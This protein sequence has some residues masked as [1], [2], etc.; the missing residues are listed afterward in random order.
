ML[1]RFFILN[2]CNFWILNQCLMVF[3][4]SSSKLDSD[5]IQLS[6]DAE[7]IINMFNTIRQQD[8]WKETLYGCRFD[9]DTFHFRN[10]QHFMLEINNDNHLKQLRLLLN[11]IIL[12]YTENLKVFRYLMNSFIQLCFQYRKSRD[13][14]FIYCSTKLQ[15]T[16]K[17]STKMFLKFYYVTNF[18][19]NI[20]NYLHDHGQLYHNS[21]ILDY[22]GTF[23]RGT[24][25]KKLDIHNMFDAN[26]VLI[27]CRNFIYDRI[28]KKI[29]PEHSISNDLRIYSYDYSVQNHIQ[30]LV[31]MKKVLFSEDV[32][33]HTKV[34][35][36][37]YMLAV[38]DSY[39]NL[40][41]NKVLVGDIKEHIHEYIAENTRYHE[42]Q[43][44]DNFDCTEEPPVLTHRLE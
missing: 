15:E 1:F 2:F 4:S 44:D 26:S 10:D 12:R 5:S 42:N 38:R 7:T 16:V 34:L 36:W 18:L 40:G 23:Y 27:I 32:D 35:N 41:F 8:G 17:I 22:M 31:N 3:C 28:D 19:Y 24:L 9:E 39:Y 30:R 25:R 6:L 43:E 21:T 33:D 37:F 29:P 14:K 11:I 13:P 20:N